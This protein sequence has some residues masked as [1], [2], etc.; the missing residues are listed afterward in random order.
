[1]YGI[2]ETGASDPTPAGRSFS[3][4]PTTTVDA[5]D[6][7][8]VPAAATV[9]RGEVLRWDVVGPSD[10][11][12]TDQAGM[13]L[14][15]SGILAAGSTYDLAFAGAGRYRYVCTLHPG[16]GGTV[17]VPVSAWPPRLTHGWSIDV[18][19]AAHGPPSGYGYDAQVRLPG[20]TGWASWLSGQT[21][22]GAGFTTDALGTYS[23]R[24]RLRQI[25][26]GHASGYSDPASVAVV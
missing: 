5:A 22:T 16:M 7:T 19:W 20:S 15:D 4:A 18:T 11:T 17:A 13:G 1:V 14:F 9:G 8:F 21:T 6:F 25:S 24:A 2:D 23:F 12:V 26:T 3:V 10:H